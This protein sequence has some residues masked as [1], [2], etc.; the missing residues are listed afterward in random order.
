MND[1]SGKPTNPPRPGRL[2]AEQAAPVLGFKKREIPIL[3]RAKLL[4]PIGNP[5]RH[6]V[7]YF[8]AVEVEKLAADQDWISRATK[9]VY[10][11]WSDQNQKRRPR[12][13]T[14]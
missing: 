10:R 4:K 11:Y 9:A 2:L 14:S 5:P 6:A 7:K 13:A 1:L 3:V 8:F 12:T